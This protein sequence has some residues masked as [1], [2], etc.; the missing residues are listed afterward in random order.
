MRFK[1]RNFKSD[2]PEVNLVPMLDV[3]M[4]VLTFFIALSIAMTGQQLAGV[5]LPGGVRP[6][7]AAEESTPDTLREA[8]VVGLNAEGQ[9][10]LDGEPADDAALSA[11]I[12]AYFAERPEGTIAL[13]ADRQLAYRDVTAVLE[14]LQAVGGN[15]IS[16]A[17]AP[18]EGPAD[19]AADPATGGAE[20]AAAPAPDP[21]ADPAGE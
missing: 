13:K 21:A 6:E 7:E 12:A 2:L 20:G 15:R 1:N 17:F 14:R 5:Q 8:L 18:G 11:A 3:L 16:L 4:T 9:L 10:L 19:S